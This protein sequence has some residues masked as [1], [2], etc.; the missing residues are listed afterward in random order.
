MSPKITFLTSLLGLSAVFASSAQ[1]E[2]IYRVQNPANHFTLFVYDSP[3]F[4]T[5][6]T[7]VPVADLAF[8]NPLNQITSVDFIPSSVTRPGHSELDVFE[9]IGVPEQFRFYPQGTFTQFGVTPGEIGSFGYPHSE[10]VV[11]VPEPSTWAVMLLGFGALG[12]A[13]YCQSIRNRASVLAAA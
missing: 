4:I 2:V 13:G 8:A 7:A 5:T 12:F 11:G 1:A 3:A 10:L 9:T 6:D